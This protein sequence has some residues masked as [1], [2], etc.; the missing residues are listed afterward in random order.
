[1][2]GITGCI[3]DKVVGFLIQNLKDL[4]YR[5]YDSV[6]IAIQ[7]NGRVRVIKSL[8]AVSLLEKKCLNLSSTC[9]IGHTRWATNGEVNLKN[10]HPH[11]SFDGKWV[12]VHNGIIENAQELKEKYLNNIDF[13]SETDSEV[14]VHLIAI[15]EGSPIEKIAKAMRLI[16]GSWA[17]AIMN[18]EERNKIYIAKNKSPIFFSKG[19]DFTMVASDPIC[20][21]EKSDYYYSLKKLNSLD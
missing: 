11:I 20:F 5:G 15:Q 16:K 18:K 21:N 8:G 10:C 13:K 12:L 3:G 9:G 19:K 6:G 4:Q 2:C 17:F 1:M 14:V 7:S